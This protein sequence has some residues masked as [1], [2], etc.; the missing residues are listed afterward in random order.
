MRILVVED[1]P[2]IADFVVVGLTEE[3]R[4]F[5][6]HRPVQSSRRGGADSRAPT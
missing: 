4:A 5:G 2:D 6:V 1:E 3:A